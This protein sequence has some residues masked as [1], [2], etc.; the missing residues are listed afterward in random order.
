MNQLFKI[1]NY[2][3]QAY[4]YQFTNKEIYFLNDYFLI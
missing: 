2:L 3:V 1:H 4:L